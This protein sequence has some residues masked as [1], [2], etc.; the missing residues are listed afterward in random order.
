MTE[1]PSIQDKSTDVHPWNFVWKGE[2]L[3]NSL[4]SNECSWVFLSKWFIVLYSTRKDDFHSDQLGLPRLNLQN[5]KSSSSKNFFLVDCKILAFELTI[6]LFLS[7]WNT[8]QLHF[9]RSHVYEK[10]AKRVVTLWI[11]SWSQVGYMLEN[12]QIIWNCITYRKKNSK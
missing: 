10:M 7:L 12:F 4:T 5:K 9:T 6:I 1:N 8:T 2:V 3:D 11:D